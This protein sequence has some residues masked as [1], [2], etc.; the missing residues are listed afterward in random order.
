MCD[1]FGYEYVVQR[2]RKQINDMIEE[3]NYT[4]RGIE[5]TLDYMY[6]IAKMDKEKANGGVGLVPWFYKIAGEFY[7]KK[8]DI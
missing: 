6:R 3:Y 5:L 2:I 7:R 1:I 8:M 4:F